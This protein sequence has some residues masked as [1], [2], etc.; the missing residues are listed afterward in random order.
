MIKITFPDGS[1]REY[2]KGTNS[3]DIAKSISEGL[4]RNVLL[5]KVNGKLQDVS[6]PINEDSA[7]ELLTWKDEEGNL[8]CGIL[9]LI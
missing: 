1:I 8:R 2:Q 3:M 7:F 9:R 4:A 6:L 5:A